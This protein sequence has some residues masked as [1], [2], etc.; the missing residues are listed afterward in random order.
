MQFNRQGGNGIRTVLG[1]FPVRNMVLHEFQSAQIMHNYRIPI[2]LGQVAFNAKEAFV[3][4]RKFGTD[5]NKPFVV[6][7]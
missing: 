3:V 5:Y 2:P 1:M 4:A 6:K 7:A